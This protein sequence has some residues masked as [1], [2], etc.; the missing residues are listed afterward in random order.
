MFSGSSGVVIPI[1][2]CAKPNIR[3]RAK[4]TSGMVIAFAPCYV[5][6][7]PEGHRFPMRKY[8]LL[9]DQLV[10]EGIATAADLFEPQSM[11]EETILLFHDPVY[12]SRTKYGEWTR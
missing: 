10:H 2:I 5:L 12:W 8:A 4:I 9:K 7:V 6:D 3:S 1:E 11:N